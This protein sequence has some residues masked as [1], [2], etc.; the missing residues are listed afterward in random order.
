MRIHGVSTRGSIEENK[1]QQQ[2]KII[3]FMSTVFHCRPDEVIPTL[4]L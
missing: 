3:T 1:Q 4:A 2:R